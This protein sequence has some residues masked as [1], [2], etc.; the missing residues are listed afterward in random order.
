M[1]PIGAKRDSTAAKRGTDALPCQYA[2]VLRMPLGSLT[3]A[4][5]YHRAIVRLWEPDWQL[6]GTN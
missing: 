6:V 5:C 4:M 3:R 1:A 2:G